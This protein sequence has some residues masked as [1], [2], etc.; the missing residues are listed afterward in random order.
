MRKGICISILTFVI[1]IDS[2][3]QVESVS[4][5]GYR[6]NNNFDLVFAANSEQ[7]VGA[8]SW[9]HFHPVTKKKRF[10][11]GYGIRLNSQRG[12]DLYYQTAP[13][14]LTSKSKGPGVLFSEIFYENID[15]VLISNSQNNSL[16]LNIN[17]QYTIKEKFDIGFDID[18]FGFSFGK[19]TTGLYKAYQSTDNGSIQAASP[20]SLNLLLISDNDIGMLNSELYGRY[21]FNKKWAVKFGAS[22]L[23]TEYTT[24]NELRLGNDRWR[25]KALMGMIG[26]TYTP[27][28]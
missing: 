9:A 23:F 21:W 16:N 3:A 25:N 1:L 17:F 7:Y 26:V 4:N 12:K 19:K 10:K 6:Y 14:I 28:K 20:T 11:I 22:F 27:F 18:V 5:K 24:E 2:Y 13:A 8:L 15:T